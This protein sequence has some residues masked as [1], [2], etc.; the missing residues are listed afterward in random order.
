CPFGPAAR[1]VWAPPAVRR[2]DRWG[3][4]A[5][6]AASPAA[7]AAAGT[8]APPAQAAQPSAYFRSADFRSA[9]FPGR[10]SYP[11]KVGIS[12]SKSS[13]EKPGRSAN[14]SIPRCC[15]FN[16]HKCKPLIILRFPA[17]KCKPTVTDSHKHDILGVS[18]NGNTRCEQLSVRAPKLN[19]IRDLDEA[20]G[21][22]C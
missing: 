21:R 6:R 16:R 22:A 13:V 11:R 2:R 1:P 14:P 4:G 7:V 10:H 8:A 3:C 9:A 5:D 17:V 15:L 18:P 19:Q 12:L 20:F